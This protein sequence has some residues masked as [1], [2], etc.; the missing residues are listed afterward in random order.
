MP[1]PLERE[2]KLHF[3]SATDARTA[4]HALGA[5][6]SYARRLQRDYLLDTADGSLAQQRSALRV[7]LESGNNRVTFKGPPQASTMKLREELET[8]V[9][10]GETLLRVL[11]RAGFHIAFRYEK[12]REE[13]TWQDVIVALDET[14]LGTFVELEGSEDGIRAAA[15]HLGRAPSDYV[16]DSYRTLFGRHR[17]AQGLPHADMVFGAA[18]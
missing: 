8:A 1:T 7:R 6:P 10:H 9:E 11:E 12:Y 5:T 15:E 14:P 16:I 4:I 3:A 13:F 18:P 2:I 17:D